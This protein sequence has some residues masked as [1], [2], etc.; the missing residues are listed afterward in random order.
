M[1][2]INILTIGSRGDVQPYLAL[3]VGL[4]RAGYQVRLTTH[5]TF[6][7]LIQSYGLDFFPI[8]G[9]VQAIVQ[10]EAGQ[11]TIES[12]RNP[13]KALSRLAQALA[14]IMTECLDNTWKS[15]QGVDLV[16]SSGTAFWGDDA[17]AR[18][19]IPSVVAM[20]QPLVKNRAFP[21]PML[22]PR[23]LGG[24]GNGLTY[25][26]FNR[27]Y[28]QLFK[29]PINHW[30][31]ETLQMRPSDACPFLSD[32]WRKL[33]KLFGYSPTVIPHPPDWDNTYHVTGYWFLDAPNDFAPPAA[34]QD[35]LADGEP[36]ISI[37]FGS[38]ATRNP[39]KLTAIALAALEKTRQRGILLTGWSGISNADLPDHILKLEAIPHDWLFPR[40]KAIVHHGGAGTTA[41]AFRSG[42]PAVVVPFF[43][44]QPFWGER[45]AQLGVS[46]SPIPKQ[47]LSAERL[48]KGI[49]AAIANPALQQRA[50]EL[51]TLIR[52][53]DGIA[54]SVQVVEF[55]LNARASYVS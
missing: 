38:M 39:E 52:A 12:G 20:L 13:L 37:G 50:S 22:P 9:N 30:R 31:Q 21:H 44:D 14:P 17:A 27:F 32:R 42:R 45:A 8:G 36:P 41:A 4:K 3:G 48:A 2:T 28:W 26:F 34:L 25:E 54:Q 7:D 40:M 43:A 19:G 51:G 35:F 1:T 46:P 55:T 23:S 24:W 29:A 15:C 6:E 18:L 49:E 11:A 53:E 10:G 47:R 33:P 16:I 5:D